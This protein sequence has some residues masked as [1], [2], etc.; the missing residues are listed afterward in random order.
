MQ[1]AHAHAP[2]SPMARRFELSTEE[3]SDLADQFVS[4]L[5]NLVG[6]AESP[7][8]DVEVRAAEL[9]VVEKKE[10]QKKKEL[11]PSVPEKRS[12]DNVGEQPVEETVSSSKAPVI[13][14]TAA[15]VAI[16]PLVQPK[17]QLVEPI[18]V[19]EQL[20][21]QSRPNQP[22]VA[23]VQQ[24]ANQELTQHLETGEVELFLNAQK[25]SAEPIAVNNAVKHSGQVAVKQVVKGEYQSEVQFRNEPIAVS[26]PQQPEGAS[27]LKGEIKI[28]KINEKNV[29][30]DESLLLPSSPELSEVKTAEPQQSINPFPGD[31]K[32][33][34]KDGAIRNEI[35][36]YLLLREM[37]GSLGAKGVLLDRMPESRDP[38]LGL[39]LANE[40]SRGVVTN[41]QG[42]AQALTARQEAIINQINKLLDRAAQA[43]DGSSFTVKIQPEELGEV[44]V[45]VTQ[46]GDQLFARIVPEHK[47]VEQTVRVG[48]NELV[49]QLI[50]SG[51]RAENIHVSVGRE[52][53]ETALF[54]GKFN[55]FSNLLGDGEGQGRSGERKTSGHGS[56]LSEGTVRSEPKAAES[57]WVA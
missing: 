21:E 24:G 32:P 27:S 28:E 12:D 47:E 55:N 17:A 57:G 52:S 23:V 9:K 39:S 30:V 22:I 53:S 40:K 41:S 35:P 51:F 44:L 37:A 25:R 15:A 4:L 48:I 8:A 3:D 26:L 45:K 19:K 11:P 20:L 31:K 43:K 16:A 2:H 6:R 49:A 34:I 14:D 38:L 7:E 29:D 10:E 42:R 33:I 54:N 56:S 50:N 18:K 13:E 1:T 36:P 5:Q 46:R